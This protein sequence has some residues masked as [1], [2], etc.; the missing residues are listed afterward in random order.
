[1]TRPRSSPRRSTGSTT[2][3]SRSRARWRSST[4]RTR[5]PVSS[6]K[7]SSGSG[8]R[9]GWSAA[10]GSTSGAR[11]ATCSAYLRL[12][13]NPA[14][15]VSLRRVLNVPKRGIGDRAEE[16]VAAYAARER[17]TFAEALRSPSEVPGLAARS[18]AAIAGFNA[19][20]ERPAGAGRDGRPGGRA[21]RGGARQDR[22]PGLAGDL[23]GPAGRHPGGEPAG[24]GVGGARVRRLRRRRRHARGLPRAG[25]ARRRR[26]RDPRRRGPRRHGDADDAAH[27][28]GPGVPRGV[29]HRHGGRGV[30][31]RQVADQPAGARGGAAARL[32]GDHPREG[33]AVPDAGSGP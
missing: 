1:M 32:R 11:S 26:G 29:P 25:G 2:R 31:A 8:C 22:L 23:A 14:D 16:Y 17:I 20:I 5:S 10:S 9:T 4:G 24:N 33:A 13:A 27:G 6:R 19:L 12:I 21:G 7:C 18:A 28:Q 15:E 30:P 3:A